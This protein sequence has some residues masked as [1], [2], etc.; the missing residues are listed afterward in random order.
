MSEDTVIT[1]REGYL[2]IEFTGEFSVAAANRT[3]DVMVN[4]CAEYQCSRVLMDCR[5]MLAGEMPIKDRVEVAVY[6]GTA[7]GPPT[8]IALLGRADQVISGHYLVESVARMRGVDVR[9]FFNE[10]LA[11]K[12]LMM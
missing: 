2:H 3:I 9:E 5:G 10:E 12:W 6:A 8:R 11:V 4:A 7:I 1:R